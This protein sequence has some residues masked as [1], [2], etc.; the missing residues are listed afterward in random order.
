MFLPAADITL[1]L[2]RPPDRVL[3]AAPNAMKPGFQGGRIQLVVA[4]VS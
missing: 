1:G 2:A 4:T 3:R